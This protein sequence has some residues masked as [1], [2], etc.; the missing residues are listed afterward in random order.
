MLLHDLI[1]LIETPFSPSHDRV[2]R[3]FQVDS[4]QISSGDI[5]F[6]LPGERTDGHHFLHKVADQGAIGA[7]VRA[8]F[9]QKQSVAF[10]SMDLI[11]VDDVLDSMQ[12]IAQQLFFQSRIPTIGI[13]GSVGKTTTKCF[14]HTLLERKYRVT[15]SPKN[16]NSQIGIP[17]T[18]LNHIR[19]DE[20]WLIL[21]LAM[22]H[23]G[24]IAQLTTI[25]PPDIAL[26][27]SVELVHACNFSGKR[28]IALA[29]GEIFSQPQTRKGIVAQGI[30]YEKKIIQ[31]GRSQKKTFGTS[32]S[33]DVSFFCDAKG[34]HIQEGK[35]HVTL[36]HFPFRAPHLLHNFVAAA[37][38]AREVGLSW[39][40]IQERI[41]SLYLPEKRF[42]WIEKGGVLFL[43]DAY[44]ACE[45]SMKA[46]LEEVGSRETEGKKIAVIGS[47]MELGAFSEE[48]H[49]RVGEHALEHVDRILCYGEECRPIYHLWQEKQRSVDL[50]LHKKDLL[51][52][53]HNEVRQGDLVLLKGSSSK[54]LWEVVD[55]WNN[56][57]ITE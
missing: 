34:I 46:A 44:N 3:S 37:L 33:A 15:V 50:F 55:A 14:L 43:N 48:C 32:C 51:Q 36:H 41:P 31:M 40:E 8:D 45:V 10:P 2:I 24:N 52:T 17:L 30:P 35:E 22:T 38:V 39:N 16:Y 42:A 47:M 25:A 18:I 21:E 53:L 57:S 20:D 1:R 11:P 49:R 23:K 5:F 27:I 28:E 9:L 7:V 13:T 54:A 26:L 6:A 29:K 56:G 4:R 19:G 12:K